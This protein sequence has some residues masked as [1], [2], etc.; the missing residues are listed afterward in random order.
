[1]SDVVRR[2]TAAEIPGLGFTRPSAGKTGTTNQYSDAWFV[3]YTPQIACGVWVGVDE[4][5]SLGYG[6]T[7]AK[8]AI[9]I[10]VKTMI[11]LHRSLP[12]K[13]FSPPSGVI[14]LSICGESN[15]IAV[16]QCSDIRKEYFSEATLPDTC[17]IHGPRHRET[18]STG[19][20]FG[21]SA[22]PSRFDKGR[23]K[24]LMF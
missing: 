7:G 16:A 22:S 1:M 3:G 12:L 4:R 19:D 20:R 15:R 17:D 11:A 23:K 24:P 10:W 14:S 13:H 9:P 8:G 5:R 2:G 6:V 21:S 18:R